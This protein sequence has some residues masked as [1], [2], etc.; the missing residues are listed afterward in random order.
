VVPTPVESPSVVTSAVTLDPFD[1][2]VEVVDESL[3]DADE[4][5]RDIV[6][7]LSGPSSECASSPHATQAA[8]RTTEENSA[9]DPRLHTPIHRAGGWYLAA[10]RRYAGFTMRRF[11]V[12][13]AALGACFDPSGS[14]TTDGGS[15]TAESNESGSSMPDDTTTAGT[16]TSADASTGTDPTTSVDASTTYDDTTTMGG[17][18]TSDATIGTET[19][20]LPNC[21]G[22]E[23]TYGL[24]D[25]APAFIISDETYA[26]E[27]APYTTDDVEEVFAAVQGH[28]ADFHVCLTREAPDAPDFTMVVVTSETYLGDPNNPGPGRNDCDDEISNS[29]NISILSE[30]AGFAVPLKAILISKSIARTFGLDSVDGVDDIMNAPA[31]STLNAATFT[32]ECLE[33]VLQ[34]TFC[35]PTFSCGAA[36]QQNSRVHLEALLGAAR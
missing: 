12:L 32:D 29:V 28:W 11:A 2:T 31:A 24:V 9:S 36:M 14:D 3:S 26:V 16:A 19:G 23:H 33:K 7:P 13:S 25:N 34:T 20:A 30:E 4:S 5:V 8:I 10:R 15:S 27:W 21:E 1:I 17:D 22:A 18:T 6:S 35:D